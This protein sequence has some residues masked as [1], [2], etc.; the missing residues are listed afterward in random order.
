MRRRVPSRKK[1]VSG[2]Q[3]FRSG[4]EGVTA[5]WLRSRGID[6]QYEKIKIKYTKPASS[7]TYTPDF[8]LPNGII[9]ET[10]GV[11]DST[12]RAKHLL[13]REQHPELDIRFVFT[14]SASPLYKGSPTSYAQWCDKNGFKFADRTIPSE[15]IKEE[16]KP[17]K[18]L[19]TLLK[20]TSC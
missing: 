2:C 12:D 7:H 20:E 17:C 10:K 6:P 8:I 15:W 4:L 1:T 5:E 9:V 14:R 16:R 3:Q 11:F 18:T 19:S 13:V